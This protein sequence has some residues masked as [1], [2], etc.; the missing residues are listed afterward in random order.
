MHRGGAELVVPAVTKAW[1][2]V[3]TLPAG[4]ARK[5]LSDEAVVRHVVR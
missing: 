5:V 2:K 1:G 4:R 3:D